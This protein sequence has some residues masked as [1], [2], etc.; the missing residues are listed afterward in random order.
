M[1]NQPIGADS[2]QQQKDG[3]VDDTTLQAD[4]MS[5]EF[6]SC[7]H[8]LT[9]CLVDMDLEADPNLMSS[10]RTSSD[11]RNH[12]IQKKTRRKAKNMAVFPTYKRGVRIGG[13]IDRKKR[14]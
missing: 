10:R 9:Q 14:K 2:A 7:R 13:W 5:Y 4:G 3:Q 12:R 1:P 11:R 6:A 8:C